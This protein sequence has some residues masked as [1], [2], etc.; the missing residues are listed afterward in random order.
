MAD[1]HGPACRYLGL[2]IFKTHPAAHEA[3]QACH[4]MSVGCIEWPVPIDPG[5]M[6]ED[7]LGDFA[8]GAVLAV[9]FQ[10]HRQRRGAANLAGVSC[11]DGLRALR[12]IDGFSPGR[13]LAHCQGIFLARAPMRDGN[14]SHRR[15]RIGNDSELE[16]TCWPVKVK[17]VDLDAGGRNTSRALPPLAHDAPGSVDADHECPRARRVPGEHGPVESGG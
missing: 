15:A 9:E 2:K 3:L 17:G 10:E 7:S 16:R 8:R 12:D 13:R 14:Q 1:D 5:L 6:V 11:L 4:A